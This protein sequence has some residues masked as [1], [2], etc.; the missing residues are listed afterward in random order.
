MA[1]E[2]GWQSQKRLQT[3]FKP[4]QPLQLFQLFLKP[5]QRLRLRMAKPETAEGQLTINP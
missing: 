1:D 2:G 4:F 3:I 5:I